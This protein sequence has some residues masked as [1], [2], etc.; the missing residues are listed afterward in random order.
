MNHKKVLIIT[1]SAD[2]Q[3]VDKVIEFIE[4]AGGTAIRFNTDQYPVASRLS[5]V[6]SNNQWQIFYDDGQSTHTLHDVSA[7]WYW[8]SHGWGKGM[9]DMIEQPYLDAGVG[10]VRRTLFGMLEGLPCFQ[11]E[12][13]HNYRRLD[14]KEEQ[15]RI[16]WEM[17]LKV[18][19]TCISNDAY[20]VRAFIEQYQGRVITKMQHAFAIHR[21]QEELVVYTNVLPESSYSELDSLQLCP[22]VFQQRIDKNLELR[23]TMVGD[24]AFAFSIDSQ[25]KENAQV[26]WRKERRSM[27]MDWQPYALPAEVEKKLLTFMDVYGVNYRAIDLILTPDDEYYFLET[28]AAGEYFWL[29]AQCGFGISRQIAEVL[30]GNVY[31]RA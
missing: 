19:P 10:E 27:I 8:R 30:M 12:R 20:R 5:T 17:G 1:Y 4:A 29:D 7:V 3:S 28:N 18:P 24:R 16:A 2:N 13:V 14:S 9:K 6:Y 25:K 23:V 22:M 11:L 26:D 21:E 15:L 31:R